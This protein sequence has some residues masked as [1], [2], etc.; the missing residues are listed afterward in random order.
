M[1]SPLRIRAQPAARLSRADGSALPATGVE[2]NV[3]GRSRQI[4]S[5]AFSL[6][7]TVPMAHCLPEQNANAIFFFS[8]PFYFLKQKLNA[9]PHERLHIV[10]GLLKSRTVRSVS[11]P[12]LHQSLAVPYHSFYSVWCR[13]LLL[14]TFKATLSAQLDAGR[15]SA[16]RINSCCHL[17]CPI[18]KCVEQE[19]WFYFAVH[20]ARNHLV[21]SQIRNVLGQVKLRP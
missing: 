3:M 2:G 8:P 13:L 6:G 10:A 21:K 7:S 18:L 5:M 16:L 9:K 14:R 17:C 12:C 20:R 19:V 11:Q 1:I 4:V 15:G